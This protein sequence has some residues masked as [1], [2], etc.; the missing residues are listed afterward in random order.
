MKK[1][2]INTCVAA[3]LP[4]IAQA[5]TGAVLSKAQAS[6]VMYETGLEARDPLMIIAAAKLRRSLGLEPATRSA[7]NTTVTEGEFLDWQ[8]MLTAARDLSEG[9]DLMLGLIED[10]EAERR[11]G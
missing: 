10:V 11:R 9:D 4:V 8:T 1:L 6:R 7:D 5:E 3:L 2:L